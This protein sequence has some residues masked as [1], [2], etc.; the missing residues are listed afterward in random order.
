MRKLWT[1]IRAAL[2]YRQAPKLLV[3]L[4]PTVPQD[5]GYPRPFNSAFYKE[6]ERL[7]GQ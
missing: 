5:C 4:E 6:L 3:P 1:W 2:G 7:R